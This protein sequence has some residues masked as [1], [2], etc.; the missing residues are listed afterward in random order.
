MENKDIHPFPGL[1]P[2]QEDEEHLFFGREKSVRELL[3]R[4]RTSRFLAVVGTSGSG[5]SSL[6]ISGLLPALYRG[7]MSGAGSRWITALSRPGENPVG[8]LAQALANTGLIGAAPV[9]DEETTG[10]GAISRKFIETTLRRS[11]RGLADIVKQSPLEKNQNLLIVVD[12]FEEL[13]RFSR[14]ERASQKDGKSDAAVFVNLLLESAKQV[15]IPVYIIIT[16]RSDFLGDCTEFRGLPEAINHGQYLIPRMTRDEK[17][18]AITGPVA[19]AGAEMARSLVSRVLNDVGDNPDQLPILQHALMRTWDYWREHREEGEPL[20]IKHYK[21]IGTMRRAL[22]PHAEEAL[23]QLKTERSLAICEKMFKLITDMGETGRGV[24]RPAK[25]SEIC[26]VTNAPREEVVEVVN[27]FRKPGRTF[28]MPPHHIQLDENSVIDISHESFM[29][30]WGRLIKWVKEESQSAELYIRLAKA[31]ALHEEGKAALWRDPELMLALKWREENKPN[32][33][34]AERYDPAFQRAI[35]FL[36]ASTKQKELE[37]A[38]KERAQKAKIKRTRIIAAAISVAAAVAIILAIWGFNSQ[39]EANKQKQ[40]AIQQ[41]AVA[42]KKEKEA[43]IQKAKAEKNEKKAQEQKK[44]AEQKEKEAHEA[45]ELAERKEALAIESE[46]RAKIAEASAKMNEQKANEKAFLEKLQGFIVD[47]N[48]ADAQ[49]RQ[50]LAKANELAIQSNAQTAGKELKVLLALTAFKLNLYAY[51]QLARSTGEISRKIDKRDI[52][53]IENNKEFADVYAKLTAERNRLQKISQSPV[54]PAVLFSAL[55][56]AYIA[57]QDSQDII[58]NQSESW[59]L[60]VTPDNKIVFNNRDGQLFLSALT[61]ALADEPNLGKI[62]AP[63]PISKQYMLAASCFA[64]GGDRLFCGTQGGRI[65]Q[66][67]QNKWNETKESIRHHSKILDMVYSPKT[68]CLIYS[69]QNTIHIHHLKN[70]TNNKIQLDEQHFIRALILIEPPGPGNPIVV[71]ADS[72]GNILQHEISH[73]PAANVKK[74]INAGFM[75]RGFHAAAYNPAGKLLALADTSGELHLF[76]QIDYESLASG[77]I[78]GYSL[79]KRKHKGIVETLAFSPDGNWMASGGLD[80]AVML[81][82][83]EGKDNAQ[84]VAHPPALIIHN[85]LKILSVTFDHKGEN[86]IFSDEKKLRICPIAPELFYKK[87]CQKNKAEFTK[88]QWRQ[89][90]GDTVKQEAFSICSPGDKMLKNEGLKNEK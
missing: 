82:N 78:I 30:I 51:Q 44:R 29:R 24:R 87:L 1:R 37:I 68:N 62:D 86:I 4:L 43:V 47:M 13:F 17:R 84:I 83:L 26:H 15:D 52:E 11:T 57:N 64:L 12:Q 50:Y 69:V 45:R 49:F 77:N 38:E 20:G 7:F 19:V 2:F 56:N 36:E 34:W 9:D 22:S 25:L 18:A 89:Y 58:Y 73:P 10:A 42:E 79:F 53:K 32:A 90:I 66:W 63:T 60:T 76:S 28:L 16:M 21:A 59:A 27:E 41:K 61:P 81:W 70:D 72:G 23:A 48:R 55:R 71:S 65:M 75:A 80:G 33:A 54:I 6:V 31:A 3:S 67:R 85:R 74:R 5:K 35:N 40:I 46:K 8:N 39:K 88:D 14:L